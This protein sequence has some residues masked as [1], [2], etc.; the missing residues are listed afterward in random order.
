MNWQYILSSLLWI[1]GLAGVLATFS[2]AA[3]QSTASGRRLSEIMRT[4]RFLAPLCIGLEFF[5][6]GM[7]IGGLVAYRRAP[8]WETLAWTIFVILFGIQAIL[9]GLAGSRY[10]WDTP[11]E[12]RNHE[13]S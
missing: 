3:W 13:R 4:P 9:Y 11:V 1:I 7:A 5:S 2:F 6:I 8:W 10:G 12:G